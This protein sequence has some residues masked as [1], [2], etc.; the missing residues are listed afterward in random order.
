MQYITVQYLVYRQ[1]M[2][3]LV[4]GVTS[5]SWPPVLHRFSPFFLT[6]CTVRRKNAR[7]E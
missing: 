6:L 7:Q 5:Q 2:Q 3:V 4:A 1:W